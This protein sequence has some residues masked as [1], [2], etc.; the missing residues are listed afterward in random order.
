MIRLSSAELEQIKR[1]PKNRVTAV[2]GKWV[3]LRLQRQ[4]RFTHSGPCPIHSPDPEARDSTSFACDDLEWACTTCQDGGDVF[5]IVA[6]RNGLDPEK[7]FRRAVDILTGGERP[8]QLS[9]EESQALEQERAEEKAAREREHNEFRDRERR[10]AW[11]LYYKY[12]MR[13]SQPRAAIGR[14]YLEQLRGIRLNPL[15]L[16][17]RFNPEARFYVQDRPKPRLIHTGPALLG[18]IQR[19]G[20]FAG[21]HMTFID[22]AQPK[23]KARIV[24]PKKGAVLDAKKVRG[25]MKGGHVD[26]TGSKEPRELYLGEGKEKVL[27]VLHALVAEG[28]DVSHAAFWSAMNLGNLGGKHAGLVPHPTL[29]TKTGRV[30][31][32]PGPV[33]DLTAPAI[34]IPDS[35]ERLVLLGDSTSDRFT[36]QNVIAR[37]AARY[38]RPGR[39]VVAAWPPEGKDFDDLLREEGA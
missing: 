14:Q 23:G 29:T 20:R 39:E 30:Q 12:G 36:T 22:L 25:S 28:R 31:G 11:D 37:A 26:L 2:V 1:D 16:V 32:V 10:A 8:R 5:R 27:A 34:E 15:G 19:G 35:V 13:L 18:L 3:T 4:G 24:D 21:V 7:D 9:A 33:P 17:L 38:A 6:L